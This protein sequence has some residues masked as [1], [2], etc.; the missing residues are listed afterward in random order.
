MAVVL[1]LTTGTVFSDTRADPINPPAV[2]QESVEL[3]VPVNRLAYACVL[4]PVMGLDTPPCIV[5]IEGRGD[6]AVREPRD[7]IE[8]VMAGCIAQDG[9]WA[10]DGATWKCVEPVGLSAVTAAMQALRDAALGSALG[11]EE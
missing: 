5:H 2:W 9:V 4:P 10:W 3:S 1:R 7:E 6:I 8:R 11:G